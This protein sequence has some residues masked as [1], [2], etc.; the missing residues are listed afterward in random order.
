MPTAS[1]KNQYVGLWGFWS[2]QTT[3]VISS[4]IFHTLFPCLQYLMWENTGKKWPIST[5]WFEMSLFY[6]D[7]IVGEYFEDPVV[8]CLCLLQVTPRGIK[9]VVCV[10]FLDYAL[11]WETPF[12]RLPLTSL[13]VKDDWARGWIC[14]HHHLPIPPIQHRLINEL[15]LRV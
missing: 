3:L 1:L 14:K 2:I 6:S 9:A 12:Y 11:P 7:G 5:W 8:I 13:R 10:L 15:F 4:R